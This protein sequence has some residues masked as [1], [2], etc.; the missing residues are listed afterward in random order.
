MRWKREMARPCGRAISVVVRQVVAACGLPATAT[1]TATGFI[2][3]VEWLA[4]SERCEERIVKGR[5]VVGPSIHRRCNWCLSNRGLDRCSRL[6]FL[7]R[8]GSVDSVC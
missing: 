5:L 1:T 3:S 4:S 2:V 8:S 6:D 7:R